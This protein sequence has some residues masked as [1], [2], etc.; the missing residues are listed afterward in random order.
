MLFL[1]RLALEMK[2]PDVSALASKLTMDQ[3]LGWMA[4]WMV[5]PFG[6]AWRRTARLWMYLAG[7]WGVK[8]EDLSES[9]FLPSH[10]RVPQT[11]AEILAQFEKIP[12]F[13]KTE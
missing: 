12:G 4:F 3:V 8:V 9:L 11:D 2:E 1:Y 6:D 13:K 5:E 10:G 7:A